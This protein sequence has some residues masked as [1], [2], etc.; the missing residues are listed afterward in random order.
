[1]SCYRAVEEKEH[2]AAKSAQNF[3][4]KFSTQVSD[5]RE[6]GMLSQFPW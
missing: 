5:I 6:S 2:C 4:N 3:N 1:M